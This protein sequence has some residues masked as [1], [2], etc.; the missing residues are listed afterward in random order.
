MYQ[1]LLKSPE[2]LFRAGEFIS[3]FQK[4][5]LEYFSTYPKELLVNHDVKSEPGH[6]F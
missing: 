2:L 3:R 5:A 4:A 1:S 6:L